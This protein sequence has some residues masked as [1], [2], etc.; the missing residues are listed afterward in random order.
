MAFQG[1]VGDFA[2][3]MEELAA[4]LPL[5]EAFG[6]QSG[7]LSWSLSVVRASFFDINR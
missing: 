1:V 5:K 2:K 3:A 6:G 4:G 7:R